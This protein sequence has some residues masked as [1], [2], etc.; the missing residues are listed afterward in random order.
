MTPAVSTLTIRFSTAGSATYRVD[1][2]GP[3]V[4]ERRGPFAP[5]YTAATWQAIMLAL[6]P[7]FM[8]A[9]AERHAVAI[10]HEGIA[11]YGRLTCLSMTLSM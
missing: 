3:D 1:L 6:E 5:P 7:G 2:E 8:Q 10:A 11:G 9:E 4:G